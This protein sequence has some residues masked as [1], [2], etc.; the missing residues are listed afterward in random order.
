VRSIVGAGLAPALVN[1]VAAVHQTRATARVAPTFSTA[2]KKIQ[3]S[4][5]KPF[6]IWRH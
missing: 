3:K 1:Y 6:L 2:S 4:E 5:T